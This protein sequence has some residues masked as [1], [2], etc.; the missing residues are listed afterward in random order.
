MEAG[1]VNE[2]DKVLLEQHLRE[3]GDARILGMLSALS[4][5]PRRVIQL[6]Y[7]LLDGHHY[8]VDETAGV[9]S[10]PVTW[11]M[12]IEDFALLQLLEFSAAAA[13]TSAC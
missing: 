12:A 7:G 4:Y 9:L 6:R 8:S 2:V 3:G 10:K 13:A 1:R 11:V 5:N